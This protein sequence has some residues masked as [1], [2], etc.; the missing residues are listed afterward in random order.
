MS[1]AHSFPRSYF[2]EEVPDKLAY[3][4]YLAWLA[5]FLLHI[6]EE[7]PQAQKNLWL[8]VQENPPEEIAAELG[9]YSFW[10]AMYVDPLVARIWHGDDYQSALR[11]V[12]EEWQD[13]YGDADPD[14]REQLEDWI[15]PAMWAD[16]G[17]ECREMQAAGMPGPLGKKNRF[18]ADWREIGVKAS[19]DPG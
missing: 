5:E 19:G 17:R 12:T 2:A 3:D 8:S 10:H 1:F 4:E 6:P 7:I 15:N 14:T 13:M 9:E 16:A 18:I 11:E